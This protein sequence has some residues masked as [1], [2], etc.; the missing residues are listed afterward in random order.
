MHAAYAHQHSKHHQCIPQHFGTNA[1]YLA[2]YDDIAS[3]LSD[4]AAKTAAARGHWA[5]SHQ[6]P[7]EEPRDGDEER[8]HRPRHVVAELRKGHGPHRQG[9]ARDDEGC[10]RQCWEEPRQHQHHEH[11]ADAEEHSADHSAKHRA[12]YWNRERYM[13]KWQSRWLPMCGG[14]R[15]D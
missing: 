12:K 3:V 9:A 14:H 6:E 13:Q 10:P 2:S 11:A 15:Q 7:D 1:S 8:G 5:D 4:T